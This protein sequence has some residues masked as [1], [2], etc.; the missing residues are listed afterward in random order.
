LSSSYVLGDDFEPYAYNQGPRGQ[1][2]LELLTKDKGQKSV[3]VKELIKKNV[4]GSLSNYKPSM[5]ERDKKL[6]T[7][8]FRE[9]VEKLQKILDRKLPWIDF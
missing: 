5:E 1:R 2:A 6:L 4:G 9:D 8:F 3:E 7:D